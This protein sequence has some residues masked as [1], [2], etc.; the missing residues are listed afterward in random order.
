MWTMLND[1]SGRQLANILIS[2]KSNHSSWVRDLTKLQTFK[3]RKN[4]NVRKQ[5]SF[6]IGKKSPISKLKTTRYL[7][8]QK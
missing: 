6:N 8:E 7:I 3:A 2:L 4:R 1:F 5:K